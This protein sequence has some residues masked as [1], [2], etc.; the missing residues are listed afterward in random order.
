MP[1][2][3]PQSRPKG[4]FLYSRKSTESE[5]RQV[6]SIGSQIDEVKQLAERLNVP[7]IEVFTEA[8][9]AK[10]PGR[11]IFNGMMRRVQA[12]EAAGILCWKLD[13]LARNPVDGGALIWAVKQQGIRIVTPTQAYSMDDDNMILMYIEFG[14]AH[15]YV[16]DLSRVVKRGLHAKA[17]SGWYPTIPPHGYLNSLNRPTGHKEVITDRER[18]PLV[19]KMWELMLTRSYSPPRI[20]EIANHQ[21]GFRTRAG[22][23]LSR[24]AIYYLFSNP[25]YTGTFEYPKR[26]GQWFKGN[27]EPMITEAE[28]ERVQARLGSKGNPRAISRLFAYTGLIRCGRCGAMITA[29]E[30][31]QLMCAVCRYKF[32]HRGKERCPRCHARVQDMLDGKTDG[33]PTL[34]DYVY[35]HCTKRKDPSCIERSIRLEH[36]EDNLADYLERLEFSERFQCWALERLRRFHEH[37]VEARNLMIRSQQG[38]YQTCLARLDNLVQLKTAPGNA[39]GSLLSDAEYATRRAALLKDKAGLEELLRDSGNR[40]AQWIGL[41]D[42]V[43]EYIRHARIWLRLQDPEIKR[44]ILAIFATDGSNLLLKDKKLAIS[45]PKPF[46]FLEESRTLA[47]AQTARF[48]PRKKRATNAQT[49]TLGGGFRAQLGQPND[50]RTYGEAGLQLVRKLREWLENAP[51]DELLALQGKLRTLFEKVKAAGRAA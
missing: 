50:V 11:P 2:T 3:N 31:H 32:V 7:I 40:V 43:F 13:R 12:G 23:P 26:S 48:E 10:E 22:R 36:L 9:S 5:D 4:F 8:C 6:L 46:P 27:H 16:D 41:V 33:K 34:L 28:Y 47:P 17:K 19:R 35:Y 15:K 1:T 49:T 42:D 14:M 30:K 18:F 25:F 39:D 24:S 20:L 29:E 45:A 44:L 38:A 51:T 37:E 21:W